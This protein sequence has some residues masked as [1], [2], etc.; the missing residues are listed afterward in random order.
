M[1]TQNKRLLN[2]QANKEYYSKSDGNWIDPRYCTKAHLVLDRIA[3]ARKW[4]HDLDAETHFDVGCK[5]GYLDLTLASEGI[6]CTAIDPSADAIDEAHL[7]NQERK[8]DVY[9]EVAYIENCNGPNRYDTVSM[10]EVLEHV[11]NPDLV[12]EKL[13]MFGKYVL[14]STPDAEG[15]RGFEDAEQNEEHVRLYT[16][17]ELEQLCSKYGTILEC[18]VRDGQLCIIFKSNVS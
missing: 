14:I 8:L 3:W 10:L 2:Q 15:Q 18:V 9:F 12:V 4:I 16:K 5:D 17:A 1:Q 13:S 11:V 7:R 6:K